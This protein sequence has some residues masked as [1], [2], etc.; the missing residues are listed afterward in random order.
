MEE[1]KICSNCKTIINK[2]QIT[3]LIYFKDNTPSFQVEGYVCPT[4]KNTVFPFDSILTFRNKY[5]DYFQNFP[6]NVRF[7]EDENPEHGRFCHN[8]MHRMLQP[9]RLR[10]LCGCSDSPYYVQKSPL[11]E[12]NTCEYFE[13]RYPE[14]RNYIETPN[15][16]LRKINKKDT[17][18]I[19]ANWAS[20]KTVTKYLTWKAHQNIQE[21]EKFVDKV[22]QGYEKDWKH[23]NYLIV[24]KHTNE[25]IGNIRA[26]IDENNIA[27]L[28]YVL[29]KKW[30]GHGVMT[31][32]TAFLIGYLFEVFHVNMVSAAC[33]EE[34]I[35]SAKV[36]QKAGMSFELKVHEKLSPNA[37][38]ETDICWYSISKEEYTMIKQIEYEEQ[39]NLDFQWFCQHHK[40]IFNKYH[41]AGYVA[42]SNFEV[43]GIYN[44]IR[45]ALNDM[46]KRG[47][48]AGTYIVQYCDGTEASF[49]AYINYLRKTPIESK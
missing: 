21:T 1:K 31:E 11:Y 49:T 17:K 29:A 28:G 9:A 13:S 45:E 40:D 15:L 43:H 19:Y 3:V 34:N 41:K 23:K 42:I 32:A 22:I 5:K 14:R 8:C 37:K 36:M 2:Q 47:Y 6:N 33:V 24:W 12:D 18:A 4:C 26:T 44:T 7:I 30:W 46:E 16:I 10:F 27:T 35:A 25:V 39:R 48:M 38:E 20:D